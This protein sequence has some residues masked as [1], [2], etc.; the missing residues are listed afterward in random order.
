MSLDY[1]G[2]GSRL[3]AIARFPNAARWRRAGPS[4]TGTGFRTSSAWPR[5]ARAPAGVV[6]EHKLLERSRVQLAVFSQQQVHLGFAIR[7]A[8]RV[9]A[10]NIGF[11][12]LRSGKRVAQRRKEKAES[13]DDDDGERQHG[14]IACAAN[15]PARSP[16]LQR[17]LQRPSQQREQDCERHRGE[18]DIDFD[19]VHHIVAHLMAHHGQDAFGRAAPQQVVVQRDALRAGEA[20][21]IGAHPVALAGGVDLVHVVCR[22]AVRVSQAQNFRA[23]RRIGQQLGGVE[24]RHNEDPERSPP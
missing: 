1:T 17:G 9:Q 6:E 12:L 23:D 7:L 2:A 22:N 20:A 14:D 18:Q 16:A 5:N 8:G 11:V 21:N 24:Q 15:A 19:V 3:V 13:G 4:E 10:V